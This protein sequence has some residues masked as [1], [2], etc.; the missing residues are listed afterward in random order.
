MSDSHVVIEIREGKL[1]LY[2]GLYFNIIHSSYMLQL[3]YFVHS[4]SR[5]QQIIFGEVLVV[6]Q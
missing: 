5:H 6:R 4:Y 3:S 1:F 2:M